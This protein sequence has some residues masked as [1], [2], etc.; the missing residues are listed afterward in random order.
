MRKCYLL[1]LLIILWLGPVALAQNV[2]INADGTAPDASAIL[3]LKSSS[4][5]ILIPRLALT[6]TTDN[7]TITTPS[8]SLLVYNTATAGSGN[9]AVTPGFYYWSGTAWTRML[10]SGASLP[11]TWKMNGNAGTNA[12]TDFIGTT[13]NK[14]LLFKVNNVKAGHIDLP[15]FNT[16][17]GYQAGKAN[18]GGYGNT[19]FGLNA[20]GSNTT[21]INNIAVGEGAMGNSTVGLNTVAIGKFT[22][23]SNTT[24]GYNVAIGISAMLNNINGYGNT[25]V[26]NSA[27]SNNISG[28]DNIG[29]GE[30]ILATNT[31]G[32]YNTA[33]GKFALSNNINGNGN[34]AIGHTA[35]IFPSDLHNATAIGANAVVGCNNCLVLGSANGING[36][37]SDVNV[38][39]GV[40]APSQPLSFRSATGG[41]VSFF[42]SGETHYG[43]GVQHNALQLYT[44]YEQ[45]DVV[46]GWGNSDAFNESVRIKGNKRIGIGTN[47]PQASLD[48]VRTTGS[49]INIRGSLMTSHFNFGDEEHTYIRGGK[50]GAHVIINDFAGAGNVG[51]GTGAPAYKLDVNGQIRCTNLFQTSDARLK[52]NIRVIAP[53]MENI[54]S[55]QAYRYDWKDNGSNELQQIGLL[56]QE[57]QQAFPE[58]VKADD[59]GILAVNYSGLV[60]V[61][62][63][64]VKEQQGQIEELRKKVEELKR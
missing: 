39:I 4:R 11:N 49:T 20:L 50:G 29:L 14:P 12:A 41:K 57:V 3:D 13:D 22:L 62:L 19:A 44:G 26:G 59:K 32:S 2:A 35:N 64:A 42:Q 54:L 40:Y 10:E 9:L 1:C 34:T 48:I 52:T 25:A 28:V 61:L 8:V 53:V 55:L 30:G 15:G 5:G 21:G 17:F 31:T 7:T 33:V 37:T 58:L 60:P 16:F 63:Q 27:L 23:G 45:A 46:F 38:G 24:G 43:I 47:D 18:T 51:V 6:G 56:A 36:A